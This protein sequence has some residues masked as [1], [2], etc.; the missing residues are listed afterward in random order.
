MLE[1]GAAP[2]KI[3]CGCMKVSNHIMT[4]VLTI[5]FSVLTLTTLGQVDN[6]K[7]FNNSDYPT[8]V[9]EYWLVDPA[10]QS[11]EVYALVSERFKLIA[12][13]EESGILKP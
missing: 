13:L 6:E 2:L 4:K 10:K 8:G 7:T 9:R 11:I 5:I 12:H 3:C 1:K